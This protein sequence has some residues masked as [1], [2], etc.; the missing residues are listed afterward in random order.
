M[1]APTAGFVAVDIALY[2]AAHGVG[3]YA[4][5]LFDGGH[6]P[7][8][9]DDC[10]AVIE[11]GGAAPLL[12]LGETIDVD[13]P[14]AMIRVRARSYDTGQGKAQA[15]FALLH[16]IA[17]QTLVT[18]GG[19]FHLLYAVQSPVHLGRDEKQRHEWSQ[20]FRGLY[21]NPQRA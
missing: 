19:L 4:T 14:I 17:E 6:L 2:L 13:Q 12:V 7:D 5:D 21:A 15:I 20:N 3:T 11:R 18:G 9:P 1:P 16:G 8:D 10:I